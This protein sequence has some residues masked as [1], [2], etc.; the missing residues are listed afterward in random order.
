MSLTRLN[1][2]RGGNSP[3][4]S[5]VFPTY[6][7]GSRLDQT[8]DELSAFVR[9]AH[10]SWELV[11]VCD[12]CTDGTVEKLR[13]WK[14]PVGTMLLVDYAPNRG[15]GYAVRQGLVAASC[16]YR[17]F[18]DIDLAYP[19]V[20]VLRVARALRAGAEVVIA[21]RSHPESQLTVPSSRL[22]YAFR[23]SL[24]SQVFG[25]LVRVLLPLKQGDTQAGLKGLSAHAVRQIVPRMG[26]DGFG[27]DC[28]LLTACVRLGLPVQELPVSVR[29]DAE[30]TTTNFR[31]TLRMVR[32]LWRIR[33]AWPAMTIDDATPTRY[34]EAG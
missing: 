18:T 19:F 16:P 23:R 20:D 28:E 14:P 13:R 2:A 21:S 26:C 33:R 9:D 22:S 24:Q 1:E 11:F 17:I 7:P 6:N 12:G 4:F 27:I 32:E 30:N 5:L 8:L 34:R 25:K 15:K 10:E 3:E 31:S 29:Y